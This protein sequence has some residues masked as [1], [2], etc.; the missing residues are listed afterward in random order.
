MADRTRVIMRH[1][2][3]RHLNIKN[4]F[5]KKIISVK[6]DTKQGR[7]ANA[8][9]VNEPSEAMR[10]RWCATAIVSVSSP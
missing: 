4:K 6:R 7:A 3:F 1:L 8:L 9:E 10:M 5:K 2:L